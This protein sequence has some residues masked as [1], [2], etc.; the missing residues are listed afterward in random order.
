[1]SA[2]KRDGVVARSGAGRTVE[3][4]ARS[5]RVGPAIE[6]SP[7]CADDGF[8]GELIRPCRC[9]AEAKFIQSQEIVAVA[10]IGPV[11][12]VEYGARQIAGTRIK[13][14]RRRTS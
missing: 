12:L 3:R 13:C 9:A 1:M 6:E 2:E 10:G 14:R 8:R 5:K 7:T 11:T 4:S